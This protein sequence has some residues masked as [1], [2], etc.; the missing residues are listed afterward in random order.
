MFK[1]FLRSVDDVGATYAARDTVG[2]KVA[3][4]AIN[5]IGSLFITRALPQDLI[6]AVRI[7]LCDPKKLCHLFSLFM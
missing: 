6:G 5:L 4:N 2:C 7:G 3:V 1:T